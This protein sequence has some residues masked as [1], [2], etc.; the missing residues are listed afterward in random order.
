MNVNFAEWLE[1]ELN[2]RQWSHGDLVRHS[3]MAGYNVSR[4]QISHILNGAR[5]AGASTCIAIAGGLGISREEVFRARGW[6]LREPKSQIQ[7]DTSPEMAQLIRELLSFPGPLQG[8]V[9]SAVRGQLRSFRLLLDRPVPPEV[10]QRLAKLEAQFKKLLP[11]EYA[12]VEKELEE[13]AEHYKAPA[14]S[15]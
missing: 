12:E 14:L 3:K 8:L 2:K 6:L 5:Q 13:L 7:P 4:A 15:G 10:E 11:A 1:A 9:V